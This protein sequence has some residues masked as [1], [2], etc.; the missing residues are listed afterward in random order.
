MI[1]HSQKSRYGRSQISDVQKKRLSA[2][3]TPLMIAHQP[4][5]RPKIPVATTTQPAHTAKLARA[6][7]ALAKPTLPTA[8]A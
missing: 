1:I 4:S 6:N 7:H 8:K 5:Q 2:R 3:P